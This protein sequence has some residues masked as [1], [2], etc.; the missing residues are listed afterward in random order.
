[1][2]VINSDKL[3]EK[4]EN[5]IIDGID[6]NICGKIEFI[7]HEE[8]YQFVIYSSTGQF[9]LQAIW[10]DEMTNEELFDT[11]LGFSEDFAKFMKD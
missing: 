7:E 4:L 8:Y 3:A 5:T 2:I 11:F 9:S 6:K 10:K 1:M